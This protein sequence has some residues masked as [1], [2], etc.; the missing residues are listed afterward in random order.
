MKTVLITGAFGFIGRTLVRRILESTDWRLIVNFRPSLP[1]GEMSSALEQDYPGRVQAWA[2]DWMA[3]PTVMAFRWKVDEVIHL[4]ANTDLRSEPAQV[5]RE[6]L[7]TSMNLLDA[8]RRL[9]AGRVWMVSSVDAFVPETPYG[10]S[11]WLMEH[12]SDIWSE[13]YRKQIRIV[14]PPL[15]FGVDQPAGKFLPTAVRALVRGEVLPIYGQWGADGFKPQM[16][17]WI[18]VETLA[19]EWIHLLEADGPREDWD[20]RLVFPGFEASVLDLALRAA[21][22]LGVKARTR[23]E[24]GWVHL[25]YWRLPWVTLAGRADGKE[26]ERFD[27]EFRRVVWRLAENE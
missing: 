4:A 10:Q 6:N 25:E 5:V 1:A 23:S 19:D 3:A 7:T 20:R 11:K 14:S 22:S 26:E 8:A 27:D 15:V 24:R 21:R 13:A 2:H 18:G 16:R 9:K 17:Q 12:V